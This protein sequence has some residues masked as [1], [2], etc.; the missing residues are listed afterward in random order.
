MVSSGK[1]FFFCNPV[2]RGGYR[3][4]LVWRFLTFLIRFLLEI[5]YNFRII[6]KGAPLNKNQKRPLWNSFLYTPLPHR[7]LPRK[8]YECIV[9]LAGHFLKTN[10]SRKGREGWKNTG[11]PKEKNTKFL[12][13]PE[14]MYLSIYI[15]E[16]SYCLPVDSCLVQESQAKQARWNTWK[17][18]SLGLEVS[19]LTLYLII[20]MV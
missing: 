11:K 16:Y 12:G 18:D 17:V 4:G 10:S 5:T 8:Q 3:G 13:H 19:L 6:F 7:S 1:V 2:P 20:C 15:Y 9:L 14:Y